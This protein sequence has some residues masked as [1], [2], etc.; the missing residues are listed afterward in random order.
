MTQRRK[1]QYKA[2]L[3]AIRYGSRLAMQRKNPQ[4]FMPYSQKKQQK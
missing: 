3:R 2:L 1:K 4:G